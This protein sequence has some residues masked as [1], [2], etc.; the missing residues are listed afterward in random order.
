M[1]SLSELLHEHKGGGIV[2]VATTPPVSELEK[3]AKKLGLAFFH[4]E[5]RKIEG[6]HQFLNHAA[7]ALRFPEYFGDNWDAFEDCLTDFS[8]LDDEVKGYVILVDHLDA[9]DQHH[10]SQLDTAIEI[11]KDAASY[12]H[13]QGKV[14]LVVLQ[15]KLPGLKDVEAV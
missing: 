9:F 1:K 2:R 3:Q 11:F 12:W 10:H 13:D 5:G 14:M 15:G 8:W 7:L 4:I 6:K